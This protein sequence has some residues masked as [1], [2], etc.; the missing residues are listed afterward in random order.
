[1]TLMVLDVESSAKRTCSRSAFHTVNGL[2]WPVAPL[3]AASASLEAPALAAAPVAGRAVARGLQ[4]TLF[5]GSLRVSG[6]A[7]VQRR[8]RSC[9]PGSRASKR[10]CQAPL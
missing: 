5:E 9:V 4:S 6:P 8:G 3:G 7:K 10:G 1:M 2:H